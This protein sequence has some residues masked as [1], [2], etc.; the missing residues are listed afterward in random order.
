MGRVRV[1]GDT[2]EVLPVAGYIAL[3]AQMR[4]RYLLKTTCSLLVLMTAAL[5]SCKDHAQKEWTEEV[6]LSSNELLTVR[7][8]ASGK[9]YRELGGPTSWIVSHSQVTFENNDIP[10]WSGNLI[11]LYI[12]H[13]GLSWNVVAT[14][15]TCEQWHDLGAPNPPYLQ[16]RSEHGNPWEEA[17]LDPNLIGREANLATPPSRDDERETITIKEKIGR[18]RGLTS[19]YKTILPYWGT[20]QD[21]FCQAGY[22]T[23]QR[24]KR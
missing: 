11:P 24:K 6:L 9:L 7:R 5:T 20:E 1:R 18:A 12:S 2:D 16:F 21:N 19:K 8:T 4:S 22:K 17:P 3:G 10:M 15:N 13:D 23:A 14:S